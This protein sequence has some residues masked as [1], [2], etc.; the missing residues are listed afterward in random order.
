VKSLVRPPMLEKITP[1]SPR[2]WKEDLLK[3]KGLGF[4]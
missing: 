1:D 2:L 3:I 4:P